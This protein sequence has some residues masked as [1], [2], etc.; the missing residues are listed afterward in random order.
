MSL[1]EPDLLASYGLAVERDD[2]REGRLAAVELPGEDAQ[3]QEAVLK[4][5]AL[6]SPPGWSVET[7]STPRMW[8]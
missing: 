8:I 7:T 5:G 6:I 4:L 2:A 1:C 3:D